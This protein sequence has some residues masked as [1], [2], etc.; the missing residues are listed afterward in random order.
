MVRH[1]RKVV[2]RLL[3]PTL[4]EAEFFQQLS[5]Y[6]KGDKQGYAH[7]YV[8]G[9]PQQG[10][11]DQPEFSR[12]YL[13]FNSQPAHDEFMASVSHQVF[14]EPLTGDTMTAVIDNALYHKMPSETIVKG[15]GETNDNTEL[16]G[17]VA[18]LNLEGLVLFESH[19]LYQQFLQDPDRFDIKQLAEDERKEK[20]KRKRKK[21]QEK[22]KAKLKKKKEE[23]K[24]KAKQA[25][26]A[27][28]QETGEPMGETHNPANEDTATSAN[29]KR[30]RTRKKKKPVDGKPTS[31]PHVPTGPAPAVSETKPRPKKPAPKKAGPKKKANPN[32]NPHPPQAN[33][34]TA[35]TPGAK[36]KPK[37]KPKKPKANAP[38]NA[39]PPQ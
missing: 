36:P 17:G 35:N 1:E 8:E 7:Y 16:S 30:K 10:V 29:A 33:A 37:P 26:L 32:A 3:P 24:L 27:R 19:P 18:S 14:T 31:S 20:L 34:N 2:V 15:S 28:L 11:Y 25:E 4:K 22:A 13:R 6:Y 21:L 5:R 23:W 12:C 39:P 9:K 38:P